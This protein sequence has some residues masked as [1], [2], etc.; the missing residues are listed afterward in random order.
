MFKEYV[1]V[2]PVRGCDRPSSNHPFQITLHVAYVH[3]FVNPT[4]FLVLHRG[5]RSATLDICCGCC[6]NLSGWLAAI[7]QEEADVTPAANLM[8]PPPPLAALK[9]PPPAL[10]LVN[11]CFMWVTVSYRMFNAWNPLMSPTYS[12][13]HI[14]YILL[15]QLYRDYNKVI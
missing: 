1:T 9:P 15:K 11:H 8:P 5:L 4:L 12:Q 3:S 7:S 13:V 6:I 2:L 10:T 14:K